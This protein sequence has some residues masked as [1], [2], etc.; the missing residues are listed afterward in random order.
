MRC[1]GLA[2]APSFFIT[3]ILQSALAFLLLP[4]K[5]KAALSPI[6]SSGLGLAFQLTILPLI[7]VLMVGFTLNASR[8]DLTDLAELWKLAGWFFK[9]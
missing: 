7:C 4:A 6:H 2:P 5:H 1:T 9:L 8:R 3:I